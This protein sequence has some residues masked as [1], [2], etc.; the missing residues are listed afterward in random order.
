MNADVAYAY[1]ERRREAEHLGEETCR[2]HA[3]QHL[4]LKTVVKVFHQY[5]CKS[6]QA[7]YMWRSQ[8]CNHPD[9]WQSEYC[10]Y[11]PLSYLS[12]DI[13]SCSNVEA[14]QLACLGGLA[15]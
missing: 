8:Q 9:A 7:K 2:L 6:L 13:R 11:N 3:L 15:S 10:I 14:R 12:N 5:G 4:R 1:R